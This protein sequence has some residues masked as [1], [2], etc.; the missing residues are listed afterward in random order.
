[1][2]FASL[3]VGSIGG[4]LLMTA[5]RTR[6]LVAPSGGIALAFIIQ[7]TRAGGLIVPA[8]IF[9]SIFL[10]ACAVIALSTSFST[11]LYHL[12]LVVWSSSF[13]SFLLV[14]AVDVWWR[15]GFKEMILCVLEQ[16]GPR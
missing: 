5:D 16:P 11:R 3:I 10:A 13:G 4:L 6:R 12:S 2:L 14:L 8:T 9:R 7:S 1:M 15:A